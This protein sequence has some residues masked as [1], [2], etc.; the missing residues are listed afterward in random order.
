M[1]RFRILLTKLRN[2]AKTFIFI[3]YINIK[4]VQRMCMY[5]LR[6]GQPPLKYFPIHEMIEIYKPFTRMDS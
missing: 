6:I 3:F 5:M 1:L 2:L 4:Y